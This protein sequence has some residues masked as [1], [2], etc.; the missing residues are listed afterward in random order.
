MVIYA[1]LAIPCLPWINTQ[2]PS[3]PWLDLLLSR[4]EG[5]EW[6]QELI[7][8]LRIVSDGPGLQSEAYTTY[9][10][11]RAHYHPSRS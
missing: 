5:K 10:E 9:P 2:P 6:A 7:C 3:R 8:Q 1:L 11:E 4:H